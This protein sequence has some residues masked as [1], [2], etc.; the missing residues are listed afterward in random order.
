MPIKATS[1]AV[2]TVS[3]RARAR[4][5]DARARS[6]PTPGRAA[7]AFANSG[8]CDTSREVGDVAPVLGA[9]AAIERRVVRFQEAAARLTERQLGGVA[10]TV[11]PRVIAAQPQAT[12]RASLEGEPQRMVV[13]RAHGGMLI[14]GP[15]LSRRRRDSRATARAAGCRF[16]VVEHTG[17]DTPLL[18]VHGPSPRKT[19]GFS[20]TWPQ[21]R[22]KRLPR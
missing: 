7:T 21:I 15:Q 11:G 4:V 22:S 16:A 10:H 3:Q 13:L 8:V 9:I 17:Y 18:S 1:L 2:V 14:D 5:D 20:C 6:S 12:G 19:P